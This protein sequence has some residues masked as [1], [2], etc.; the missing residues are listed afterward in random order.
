MRALLSLLTLAVL[1]V[2]FNY[3]PRP[4]VE[5]C[6]GQDIPAESPVLVSIDPLDSV[7]TTLRIAVN[8]MT[9]EF[10]AYHEMKLKMQQTMFSLHEDS[11]VEICV[12]IEEPSVKG[13]DV[14]VLWGAGVHDYNHLLSTNDT[15]Y[16]NDR[17][18]SL[19]DKVWAA[20]KLMLSLRRRESRMRKTSDSVNRGVMGLSMLNAAL[21]AVLVLVEVLSFKRFLRK[22]KVI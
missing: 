6:F 11:Q 5:K 1:A 21:M 7:N 20:E 4:G 2:E 19:E 10:E 8:S 22:K 9:D 18:H 17:I 14:K 13:V 3:K 15:D 12:R 16:L